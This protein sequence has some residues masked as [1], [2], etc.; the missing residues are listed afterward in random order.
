MRDRSPMGHIGHPAVAS[1]EKGEAL[2]RV[3]AE[4]VS[5]YLQRM[6][7]WSGDSWNL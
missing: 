1:A 6:I 4:G 7:N 5:R 2:F 3:F